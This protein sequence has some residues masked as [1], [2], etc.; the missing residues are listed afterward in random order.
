MFKSI[1]KSLEEERLN[2]VTNSEHKA[3]IEIGDDELFAIEAHFNLH[4]NENII[5]LKDMADVP[6]VLI[7]MDHS[8]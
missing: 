2:V 8:N 3:F 1:W 6:G 4:S 7:T 5:S